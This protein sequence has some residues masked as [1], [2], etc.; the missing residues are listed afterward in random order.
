MCSGRNTQNNMKEHDLEEC[1]Y[2]Q[3]TYSARYILE[4]LNNEDG[5]REMEKLTGFPM[6]VISEAFKNI[7]CEGW[8]K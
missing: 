1:P 2:W 5:M 6:G 3:A 4:D 8:D 7:F